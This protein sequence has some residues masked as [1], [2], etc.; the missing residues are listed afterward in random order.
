MMVENIDADCFEFGGVVLFA[1]TAYSFLLLH[2]IETCFLRICYIMYVIIY[3]LFDEQYCCQLAWFPRLNRYDLG[4]NK[5]EIMGYII[6]LYNLFK[7]TR[8]QSILL[9]KMFLSN[10]F[11]NVLFSKKMYIVS[12]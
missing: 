2:N 4:R 9:C 10:V 1:E 5:T 11:N 12:V 7:A 6:G 3:M 8:R